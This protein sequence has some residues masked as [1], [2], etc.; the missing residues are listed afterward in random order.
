M[1]AELDD[2]MLSLNEAIQECIVQAEN[3][4]NMDGVLE[5]VIGNRKE[6]R[7]LHLDKAAGE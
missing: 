6:Q 2:K 3:R 4:D 5:N 7:S 1:V